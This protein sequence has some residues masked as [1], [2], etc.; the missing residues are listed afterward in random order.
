MSRMRSGDYE[1]ELPMTSGFSEQVVSPAEF[2]VNGCHSACSGFEFFEAT[3]NAD[4]V[5]ICVYFF[6]RSKL[7]IDFGNL[8]APAVSPYLDKR[9]MFER[10]PGNFVLDHC[11]TPVRGNKTGRSNFRSSVGILYLKRLLAKG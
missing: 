1:G 2:I 4:Y 5:P 8:L 9:Q 10:L 6:P 11:I 3:M 7:N